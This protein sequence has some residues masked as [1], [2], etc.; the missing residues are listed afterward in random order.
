MESEHKKVLTE[1][2]TVESVSVDSMATPEDYIVRQIAILDEDIARLQREKIEAGR[3]ASNAALM[4]MYE[5]RCPEV[6]E[7]LWG[8]FADPSA[9]AC[10]KDAIRRRLKQQVELRKSA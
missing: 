5:T 8:D 9:V 4:E 7:D 6:D 2:E 1:Y 3:I 10:V